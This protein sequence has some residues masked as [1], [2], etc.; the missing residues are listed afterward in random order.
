M[1]D[2]HRL[3]NPLKFF[4]MD[5]SYPLRGL[6]NHECPECGRAFDPKDP[7]TYSPTASRWSL[8][9]PYDAICAMIF[10][11][12]MAVVLIEAWIGS[13]QHW[14]WRHGDL[15]GLV[16]PPF[17][18]GL[19]SIIV[20]QYVSDRKPPHTDTYTA[21]ATGIG[22]L[23]LAGDGREMTV[24]VLAFSMA[25][26]AVLVVRA[27]TRRAWWSRRLAVLAVLVGCLGWLSVF[28]QV[29]LHRADFYDYWT[30]WFWTSQR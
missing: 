28:S 17:V 12:P 5:C 18:L 15:N 14:W 11:I 27:W 21:I 20:C 22:L 10:A 25:F 6:A 7:S 9:I 8:Q 2:E 23:V 16:T 13:L 26:I 4:C 1:G 29:P 3:L 19:V 24:F 30:Y